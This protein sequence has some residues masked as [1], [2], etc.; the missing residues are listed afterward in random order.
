MLMLACETKVN[1]YSNFEELEKCN[2]Y[3]PLQRDLKL[4]TKFGFFSDMYF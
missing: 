4:Q 2:I 3:L 1:L